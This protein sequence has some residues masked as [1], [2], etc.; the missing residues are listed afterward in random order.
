MAAAQDLWAVSLHQAALQAGCE[1]PPDAAISLFAHVPELDALCLGLSTGEL[2]LLSTAGGTDKGWPNGGPALEEVGAVEGGVAAGQWSPDGELLALL[3]GGGQL[4]MMSK[5]GSSLA[6][7]LSC[8][9]AR[10]RT[11]A[12]QDLCF[13]YAVRSPCIPCSLDH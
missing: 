6:G 12:W 5:V 1:L 4:L 13:C 11:R 7:S 10:G 9:E 3:T 2:L 8:Y